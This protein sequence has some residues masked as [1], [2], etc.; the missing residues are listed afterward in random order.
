M[1]TL[2]GT[3]VMPSSSGP[4]CASPEILRSCRIGKQFILVLVIEMAAFGIG[5]VSLGAGGLVTYAAAARSASIFGLSRHRGSRSRRALAL[6]FDD[7][8]SDSTPRLLAFLDL[9]SIRATFFMCGQ[10][11]R[12]HP[13]I[14]RA[15]VAA[16]HEIG[17]HTDSHP[18]LLF[19]SPKFVEWE[20]VSAQQT[21]Y[22]VTGQAPRLFRAPFGVRWFGLCK[23]QEALGL[24]G[25]M[26]TVIGHDWKWP[27]ERIAKWVLDH[28]DNG[29]IV[30]LH[31][32]FQT[33]PAPDISA[34]IGSLELLIPELKERGYSFETAGEILNLGDAPAET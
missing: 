20:I 17:N 3:T 34:M 29:G 23:V 18:N 30:C 33:R 2:D 8:P 24:M 7:G 21:L 9:H 13:Q 26:W 11:A 6:T 16:G 1:G 19:H 15:V 10:N 12:R 28:I 27:P 25:V 22:D 5:A 32:G 4:A 31:D 14:A